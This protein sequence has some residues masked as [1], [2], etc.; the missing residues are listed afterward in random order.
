MTDQRWLHPLAAAEPHEHDPLARLVCLP[1]AGGSPSAFRDWPRHLDSRI[2]ALAICYPGRHDRFADPVVTAMAD[3]AREVAAA[4]APLADRPLWL[5]GHSMGAAIAY[6]TVRVLADVHGV[7]PAGLVVSGFPPPHRL[8]TGNA[9]HLQGD[10]AIIADV[11]GMGAAD[12]AVLAEPELR[13]L[14]LPALRADYTLIETYRPAPAEPL[15]IPLIVAYGTDDE[16]A[17]GPADEWARHSSGNTEK[18]PLPGGHF[19]LQ[20]RAEEL[21]SR[22][23]QRILATAGRS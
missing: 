16:D 17:A 5:F 1:H 2:E 9:I 7:R 6:E 10:D 21:L 4:L 8:P 19:Y 23:S 14:V 13:E 20:D 15:G 22:L 11:L 3:M 12:R 18:L